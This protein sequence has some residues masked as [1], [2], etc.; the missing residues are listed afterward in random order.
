MPLDQEDMKSRW[1]LMDL[2]TRWLEKQLI[3]EE[4]TH[5]GLGSTPSKA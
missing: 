3:R 1:G 2:S 4:V 5:L